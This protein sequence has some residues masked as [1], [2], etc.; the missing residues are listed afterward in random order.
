M[1]DDDTGALYFRS[2]ERG[3]AG[4]GADGGGQAAIHLDRA[5]LLQS[6]V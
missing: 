3:L 1:N 5:L 6:Y 4:A 2:K